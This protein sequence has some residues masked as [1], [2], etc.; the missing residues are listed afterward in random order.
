MLKKDF[1][2]NL[3]DMPKTDDDI[4]AEVEKY[5]GENN[6]SVDLIKRTSPVIAKIEENNYEIVK[7]YQN[8]R[9]L[10]HWVLSFKEVS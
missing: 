3:N 7:K 8:G 1:L 2:V 4:C 10:N 9:F 6:L 5:C